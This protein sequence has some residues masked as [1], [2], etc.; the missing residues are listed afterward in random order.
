MLLL[1]SEDIIDYFSQIIKR[2]LGLNLNLRKIYNNQSTPINE[3]IDSQVQSAPTT[4]A[5][6][7][8]ISEEAESL[9]PNNEPVINVQERIIPEPIPQD[10]YNKI[11]TI[12]EEYLAEFRREILD[13]ISRLEQRVILLEQ[14]LRAPQKG[15]ISQQPSITFATYGSLQTSDIEL[16]LHEAKELLSSSSVDLIRLIRLEAVEWQ[17]LKALS[18]NKDKIEIPQDFMKN[19]RIEI[20]RLRKLLLE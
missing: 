3:P 16:I 7:E 8:V 18:K 4:P 2:E 20:N 9:L 17:L 14:Q 15:K 5:T 6:F 12:I 1:S 19:L 11:V 13:R 10:L